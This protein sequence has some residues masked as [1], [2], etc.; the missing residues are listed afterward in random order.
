MT[1][2]ASVV[3]ENKYPHIFHKTSPTTRRLAELHWLL[4]KN[5]S[6]GY[7]KDIKIISRKKVL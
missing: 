6:H 7:H 2:S 1:N 3:S 4:H 5:K